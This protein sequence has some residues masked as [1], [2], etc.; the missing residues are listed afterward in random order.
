[1]RSK[2]QLLLINPPANADV[3]KQLHLE[4]LGLGYVAAAVRRDL[5]ESHKAHIWD[6]SIV[7][8]AGKCIQPLL[9]K[10]SPDYVGLS[11]STMNAD[12][13]VQVA[14]QIKAFDPSIRI[15]VGGILPTSL[16]T[17]ELGLFHPDAIVRGE[18]EALVSPLLIALDAAAGT[19]GRDVLE[20]SQDVPLDVDAL[21]WPSRDMLP[22]QLRLHPQASISASRGCPYRCSFCSIP[23]PGGKKGWRARNIEDVVAEMAFIHKR[24]HCAHFY[25]V[26]DNFVLPTASSRQRAERFA[27]LV[28]E[29]LPDIRFGFMCRS[30]AIAPQLFKLLKKAGL[31]G[32]F[33]PFPDGNIRNAAAA[34][35]EMRPTDGRIRRGTLGV[36]GFFARSAP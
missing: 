35:G 1:M 32:I 22:W 36:A 3:G 26:D 24:H 5:G 28:L 23:Q 16:A 2:K 14:A 19:G 12:R 33:L 15:V 34:S 25:F 4:N 30:A 10:L 31:A 27:H 6:C 17:D 8:P 18:G 20:V 11:L 9:Q 21:G 29:Q 13:G 7:D